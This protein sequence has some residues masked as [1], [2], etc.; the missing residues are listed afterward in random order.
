M[1][2][3]K[4][5][6]LVW[7]CPLFVWDIKLRHERWTD[8]DDKTFKTSWAAL[9]NWEYLRKTRKEALMFCKHCS[10]PSRVSPK[11]QPIRLELTLRVDAI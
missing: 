6:L 7:T 8:P 11:C 9:G 5:S 10:K 3:V 4:S 1:K 2:P